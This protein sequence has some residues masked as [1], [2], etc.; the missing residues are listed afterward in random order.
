MMHCRLSE[1]IPQLF[2]SVFFVAFL[3]ANYQVNLGGLSGTDHI[4][5]LLYRSAFDRPKKQF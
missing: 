4:A 5:L 1:R 2:L 3:K